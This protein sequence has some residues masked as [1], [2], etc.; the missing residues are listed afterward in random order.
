MENKQKYNLE[1][2]VGVFKHHLFKRAS[3]ACF[4]SEQLVKST[5]TKYVVSAQK[6]NWEGTLNRAVTN[7]IL[8]LISIKHASWNISWFE[9]AK[10]FV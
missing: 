9:V 1:Q 7:F 2:K 8:N 6:L 3:D 10:M 4:Q 5:D